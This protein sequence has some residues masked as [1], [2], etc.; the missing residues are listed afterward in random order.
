MGRNEGVYAAFALLAS[1]GA[2]VTSLDGSFVL[3]L[4]LGVCGLVAASWVGRPVKS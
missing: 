2:V 4:A 3:G 1:V